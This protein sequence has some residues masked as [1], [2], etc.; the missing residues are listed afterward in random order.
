MVAIKIREELSSA[1]PLAQTN[2]AYKCRFLQIKRSNK[3]Y[4]ACE[5]DQLELWQRELSI[6]GCG[7]EI[8]HLKI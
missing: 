3:T 1:K 6:A 7:G 5:V 2:S 4:I 8:S